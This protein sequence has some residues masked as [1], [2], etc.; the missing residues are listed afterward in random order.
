[1]LFQVYS[2]KD[3]MSG[4]IQP[5]FEQN[6]LLARRNFAFAVNKTD[7]MLF[8]NSNDFA[9]YHIGTF[10]TDTG[11][12]EPCIPELIVRADTIKREVK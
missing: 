7:G 12:I 5:T 6:E 3:D 1:M 10:D 11:C 9:L 8:A 4:F 2:V